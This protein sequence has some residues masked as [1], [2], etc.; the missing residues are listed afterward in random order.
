MTRSEWLRM[1]IEQQVAAADAT[2][3]SHAIYFELTVLL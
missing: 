3:D 1:A 2:V